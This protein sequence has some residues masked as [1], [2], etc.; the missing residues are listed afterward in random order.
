MEELQGEHGD[1][2]AANL[3][4]RLKDSK[5]LKWLKGERSGSQVFIFNCR[6][7]VR[8][9]DWMWE[10]WKDLDGV[11]PE[12]LEVYVPDL[13]TTIKLPRPVE[14]SVGSMATCRTL[15]RSKV[16]KT[17]VDALKQFPTFDML[18]E[19]V[20]RET[21]EM[22]RLEL[23]WKREEYLEWISK[24]DEKRSEGCKREWALLA[25][26]SI[27]SVS[28]DSVL[29]AFQLVLIHPIYI[30]RPITHVSSFVRLGIQRQ[31]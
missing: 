13:Q 2:R 16:L 8:A 3:R 26:L 18:I 12:T 22:P 4:R 10:I 29:C 5:Q 30:S 20:R 24:H 28:T 19:S 21:G 17:A 15:S 25:G 14:D 6:E 1:H 23:A 31:C 27:I 11:L 7:R 9:M